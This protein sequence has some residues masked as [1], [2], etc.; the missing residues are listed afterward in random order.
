MRF[1]GRMIPLV[2]F[3]F[4]LGACGGGDASSETTTTVPSTTT[5]VPPTTATSAPVVTT[6]TTTTDPGAPA[7]AFVAAIQQQLLWLGFFDAEIDGIYGP[8]TVAAVEAFQKDAGI[9]VDGEYGPETAEALATAI[10]ADTEFVEGLQADL[11][12]LGYYSGPED[13]KYGSGTKAGVQALQRSCDL[14]QD[15]R[16][17][18]LTHVCLDTAMGDV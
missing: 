3:A 17:W 2:V 11:I 5:T 10:E 13:G 12:E 1:V 4:A 8:F 16:F 18:P 6:T 9:T 15:G 7:T 14:E